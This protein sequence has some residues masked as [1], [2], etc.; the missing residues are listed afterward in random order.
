MRGWQY[1]AENP[2]EAAQIVLDNDETGAQTL[3]HQPA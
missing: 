2:E 1:A 3:E